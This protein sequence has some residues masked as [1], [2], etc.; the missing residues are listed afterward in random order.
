MAEPTRF[1]LLCDQYRPVLRSV[2]ESRIDLRLLQ[3]VDP[4]DIVQEALLE[5]FSRLEEFEQKRPMPLAAW[6][7]KTTLQ[8]LAIA[9]RKHRHA[10]RRSVLRQVSYEQSSV[11]RLA[12]QVTAIQNTA[13]DRH[14]FVEEAQRTWN[15]LNQLPGIDREILTLR[16]VHGLSNQTAAELLGV[17]ETVASKRHCRALL[18]LQR[19]LLDSHANKQI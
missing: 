4:S 1:E 17:S 6:L 8:Q 11:F 13:E 2:V 5:A 15:C 10:V 9:Y 19:S 14:Q 12:E 3:R 7:R 18:R 16:Y